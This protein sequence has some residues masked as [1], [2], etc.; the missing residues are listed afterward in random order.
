MDPGV[1]AIQLL[2]GLAYGFLLFLLA[3]GLALIFG[4]MDVLNLAHGSLY[5]L[6]AYFALSVSSQWGGFWLALI[7][8]PLGVALVAVLI[9]A[10][11]LRP[12]YARGHLD[13][14][15]LTFGLAYI[16]H[17]VV[18]WTWGAEVRALPLPPV[19][20]GSA[21]VFGQT[22]PRYRLAVV[23]FG[24]AVALLLC[25]LQA[26]TRWGA[27]VRAGVSDG[28]MVSGL[29]INIRLVFTM[30]FAFGALL[31]GLAGVIAGPILGLY[32]GMD[33]ET[34]ILALIVVVVGGMGSFT[35]TLG[36]SLLIGLADTFGKAW[37]PEASLF[38]I[39]VIMAGVLVVR[40]AG[41]FS[42]ATA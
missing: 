35:A 13:Q 5:M 31:A 29:G 23:G 28:E 10:V 3:A 34:L 33:F 15:L 19:L 36:G 37:F 18:R 11:L 12:T 2:N 17:D 4:M 16:I 8:A 21:E 7:V 22:F 40:P 20:S 42:R 27:I 38:L 6:G 32:P 41:L 9:E 26:R 1:L 30:V 14:V 39:F 24:A 25:W